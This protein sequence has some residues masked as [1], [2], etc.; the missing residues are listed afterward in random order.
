MIYAVYRRRKDLPQNKWTVIWCGSY[1]EAN[2]FFG[3]LHGRKGLQH[4]YCWIVICSWWQ[5]P[6]WGLKSNEGV[7]PTLK[8]LRLGPPLILSEGRDSRASQIF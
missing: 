2:V 1:E 7:H 4:Y 5:S 3:D 8:K 6:L